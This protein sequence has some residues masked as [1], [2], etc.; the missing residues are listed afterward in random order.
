MKAMEFQSKF[1]HYVLVNNYSLLQV[2]DNK[3]AVFFKLQQYLQLVHFEDLNNTLI[4][5]TTFIYIM[6]CGCKLNDK[7]VN[8][9]ICISKRKQFYQ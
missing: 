3:T 4:H 1:L 6:T 5:F 2:K 7:D 9:I 8:I